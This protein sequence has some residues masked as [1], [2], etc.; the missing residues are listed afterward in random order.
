[1]IVELYLYYKTNIMHPT[2]VTYTRRGVIYDSKLRRDYDYRGVVVNYD[3]DMFIVL[4][5]DC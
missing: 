4:A 5:T 1:M 2:G 3:C